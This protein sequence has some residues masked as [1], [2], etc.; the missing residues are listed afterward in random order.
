MIDKKLL[1]VNSAIFNMLSGQEEFRL[2][3]RERPELGFEGQTFDP[4]LTDLDQVMSMVLFKE[5][6]QHLTQGVSF[7]NTT[8]LRPV[9]VELDS[10]GYAYWILATSI[11]DRIVEEIGKPEYLVLKRHLYRIW[12]NALPRKIGGA[13]F[14]KPSDVRLSDRTISFKMNE[15]EFTLD[16]EKILPKKNGRT[17]E[18]QLQNNLLV[19]K[20]TGRKWIADLAFRSTG[21]EG[22]I[23]NALHG[24]TQITLDALRDNLTPMPLTTSIGSIPSNIVFDL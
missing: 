10:L 15:I 24:K 5:R 16:L 7:G 19:I 6:L 2:L 9:D 23:R 14:A 1:L 4:T 22:L 11:Q 20:D 8:Y 18:L 21:W 3:D 12:F 17:V 13:I